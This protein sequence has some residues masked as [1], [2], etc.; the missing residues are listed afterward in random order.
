MDVTETELLDAIG[1]LLDEPAPDVIVGV[2]DDAAVVRGGS[3]DLVL[4]TDAMVQDQHF[5]LG[6]TAPRDLGAKAVTVSAS[7]LAAMAASPRFG[8][9]ALTLSD[10]VDAAWTMELFGGIREA[11][12]GYAVR[13]VGGNLSR[14]DLVT[15]TVT[16]S[17]EVAP[18][19]AVTRAGARP[20]DE[21]VVTGTL[22]GAAAGLRL[23]RR[24]G[25]W[26]EP[27]LAAIRRQV[28]PTARVGEAAVIARHGVTAMIDVS[29][30]LLRDL[31]RICDASGVGARLRQDDVPLDPAA[32]VEEAMGG[33]E[34]YELLATLPTAD[35][36]SEA[37]GELREAFGVPLTPIGTVIEGSGIVAAGPGGQ[38]L[39]GAGWDHFRRGS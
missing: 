10:R 4:T 31:G 30:G 34:D 7:D 13:M 29:D 37:A 15:V 16:L 18:G 19:R 25:G 33:G 28:R 9:C 3:G 5:E 22:G 24:R 1:R 17:G 12:E 39:A 27:E 23:G 20:G 35:A 14:G 11:C 38:P 6:A 26:G 8:L 36:V 32:T 2:G 21:L